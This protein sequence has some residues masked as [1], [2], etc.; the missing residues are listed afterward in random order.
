MKQ[1]QFVDRPFNYSATQLY[2]KNQYD[3]LIRLNIGDDLIISL[4]QKDV[5]TLEE[6]INMGELKERKR[7]EYLLDRIIIPSLKSDYSHK[8]I[9]FLNVMKSSDD[10][11]VKNVASDLI[12]LLV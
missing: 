9:N 4:Y 3:K 5:I 8:Y 11:L 7:M 12:S 1:S 10:G 2:L 6:K